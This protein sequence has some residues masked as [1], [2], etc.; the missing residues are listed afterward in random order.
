[1]FKKKNLNVS[2]LSEHSIP[3]SGGRDVKTFSWDHRLQRPKKND[4]T[5]TRAPKKMDFQCVFYPTVFTAE[6]GQPKKQKNDER[7]GGRD[8]FSETADSIS[9]ST[10]NSNPKTSKS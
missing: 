10:I 2:R 7:Y 4:K 3:Q 6:N 5:K 8:V 1:M 9:N